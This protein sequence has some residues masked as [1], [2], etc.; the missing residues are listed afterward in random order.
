VKAEWAGTLYPCVPGH[1]IVGRV[2]AVGAHVHG[3]RAGD[4]VGVG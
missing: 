4:L 2:S 3:F 1:E